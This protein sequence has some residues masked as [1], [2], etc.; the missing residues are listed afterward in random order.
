MLKATLRPVGLDGWA[1][2]DPDHDGLTNYEEFMIGTDPL[3][4]DTDGDG[5]SD[6]WEVA[7]GFD[8]RVPQL[9]LPEPD[10]DGD[11]VADRWEALFGTPTNDPSYWCG[12]YP[13]LDLDGD[14]FVFWYET[15][16]LGTDDFSPN[17]PGAPEAY[18]TD[19]LAD[20]VSSRPCVLR[21]VGDGRTIEIPWMPGLS[22]TQLRLRLTR[23]QQYQAT[24]SR[25]PA[26]W[27]FPTDGFWW[28]NLSFKPVLDLPDLALPP[29]TVGG[30]TT[31][32]V[33]T[34]QIQTPDRGADFWLA[35]GVAATPTNNLSACRINIQ[36]TDA[37]CHS[38]TNG[39]LRLTDDSL[40]PGT[41]EWVDLPSGNVRTGNP[42]T[43]DPSTVPAGRYTVT[44]RSAANHLVAN[45]V[46]V[47]VLH[48]GVQQSTVWLSAAD[49]NPYTIALS[50]DT[51][52]T[53]DIYIWSDPY[54]AINSLT[55]TPSSLTP[56]TYTVYLSQG[57]CEVAQVTVDVVQV[58]LDADSDRNG[59]VDGTDAEDA[60]ETASPAIM[61]F[62]NDDGDGK[63]APNVD[64]EDNIVNGSVDVGH[65]APLVLRAIPNMPAGCKAVLSVSSSDSDHI[66]IFDGRRN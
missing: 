7:H 20:I 58:D 3:V 66:R 9:G 11:L 61:I 43:F 52:P 6:A 26:G 51:G 33:G 38:S 57:A 10:S 42:M 16:V 14:G 13:Y 62:N 39:T 5:P 64:S 8:P 25:V 29:E 2:A 30:T 21:L 17:W 54:G 56:G 47:V 53:D 15:E 46:E 40:V 19:V 41:V 28:A 34:V 36:W 35:P 44:A 24:L 45:T 48:V 49:S 22:P 1:D 12:P 50:Q 18:Q 60:I 32:Y 31:Y 4:A 65:L 59:T 37:F 55:F 27:S 23:G 63:Q